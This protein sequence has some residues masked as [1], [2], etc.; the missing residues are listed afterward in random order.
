M[1]KSVLV[2]AD[3]IKQLLT[4]PHGLEVILHALKANATF[5]PDTLATL[6]QLLD[7]AKSQIAGSTLVMPQVFTNEAQASPAGASWQESAAGVEPLEATLPGAAGTN[8]GFG[9]SREE[10][11]ET[12]IRLLLETEERLDPNRL[13]VEDVEKLDLCNDLGMD[14]LG[15][16]MF[17]LAVDEHF[18]IAVPEHVAAHLQLVGDWVQYLWTGDEPKNGG[19][20]DT[21]HTEEKHTDC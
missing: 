14:S 19:Y 9:L 8:F 7:E 2:S 10:L 21:P 12:V 13:K 1:S 6:E 3:T 4:Q 11:K 16:V 17:G 18:D 15:T 5:T 20:F